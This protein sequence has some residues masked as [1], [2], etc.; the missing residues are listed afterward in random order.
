MILI[1]ADGIERCKILAPWRLLNTAAPPLFH[2]LGVAGLGPNPLPKR[3]P[4]ASIEGR[5]GNT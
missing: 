2:D 4:D 5:Y 1:P 3:F